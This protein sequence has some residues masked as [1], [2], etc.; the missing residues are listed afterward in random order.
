MSIDSSELLQRAKDNDLLDRGAALTYYGLLGLVPA[1]LVLFSLFGLFGTRDDVESSLTVLGALVPGNRDQGT[2]EQFAD[3]LRNDAASGALLGVGLV[4]VAWTASAYVGS[5]FRASA[6]IWGVPQRPVWRAWPARLGLTLALLFL[7]ALALTAIVV[8][9]HLAEEIGDA[10]SL[11][12][13]AVTLYEIVK[14]PAVLVLL[15]L[16]VGLL[17]RGSPSAPRTLARWWVVTPGGAFT[18]LSWLVVSGVFTVY[19]NVFGS[20][21]TSYGALGATIASMIWL[22]L[23]N[24]VLLAGVSVDAEL[25]NWRAAARAR[26]DAR[27]A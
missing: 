21:Q 25:E 24:L 10:L 18:V 5:F 26:R 20:Y 23:I 1:M 15:V 9:G 8:T 27:T 12:E 6:R 19:V 22:W 3:V 2:R 11:T 16:L 4:G 13:A 17:Y 7:A 14:W